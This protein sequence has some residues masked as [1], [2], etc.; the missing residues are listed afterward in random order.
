MVK[1]RFYH[2]QPGLT[3][4][5]NCDTVSETRLNSVFQLPGN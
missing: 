2:E 1:I 3:I 5:T 4:R